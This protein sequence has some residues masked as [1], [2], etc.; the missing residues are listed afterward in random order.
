MPRGTLDSFKE[1]P[2]VNSKLVLLAIN[3]TSSENHLRF[4]NNLNKGRTIIIKIQ[5]YHYTQ[6]SLVKNQVRC[7]QELSQPV[8]LARMQESEESSD[9]DS[10]ASF[11]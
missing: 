1:E 11:I 9:F 5:Q 3:P 6:Y 8:Y 4:Y 2:F 7:D 10:E